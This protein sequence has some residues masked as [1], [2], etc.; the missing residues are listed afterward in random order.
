MDAIAAR[1]LARMQEVLY[2]ALTPCW[3]KAGIGKPWM[4]MNF[5]ESGNQVDGKP[6]R[7]GAWDHAYADQ[8]KLLIANATTAMRI[9]ILTA[10][11]AM[12]QNPI[13]T[14]PESSFWAP[15]MRLAPTRSSG[16]Q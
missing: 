1:Q 16:E 14:P 4:V 9:E 12:I 3:M 2:W 7:G 10:A 8:G 11:D 6:T 15:T 5:M 13:A